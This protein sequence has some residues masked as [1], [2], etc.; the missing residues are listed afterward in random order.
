MSPALLACKEK[1][2]LRQLLRLWRKRSSVRRKIPF[3]RRV[4]SRTKRRARVLL[5]SI[6]L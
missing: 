5:R 2:M 3:Q 6:T 1:L 4:R